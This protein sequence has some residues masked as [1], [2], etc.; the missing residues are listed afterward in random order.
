M[1]FADNIVLMD[2]TRCGV[3]VKLKIWW[4]ALKSKGSWLSRTKTTY[5]ECKFSKSRNKE[6]EAIRLDGQKIPKSESF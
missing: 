1:P 3:S 5:M 4:D 2:E 6:E